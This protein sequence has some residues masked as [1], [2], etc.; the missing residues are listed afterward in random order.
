MIDRI[1]IY[2]MLTCI[3]LCA[4]LANLISSSA[5]VFFLFLK[6]FLNEL[7]V[8]IIDAHDREISLITRS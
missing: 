3:Y 6:A 1:K 5:S 8:I 2:K 4:H 7:D